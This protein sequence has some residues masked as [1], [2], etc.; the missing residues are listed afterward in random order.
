MCRKCADPQLFFV[1]VADSKVLFTHVCCLLRDFWGLA[2]KANRSAVYR[3]T[4]SAVDL[5]NDILMYLNDVFLC[6]VMQVSAV[7]QERLLRFAVLPVLLGSALQV[8]PKP[9]LTQET[10]WYLLNDLMATLRSHHV[11]T[12]LATS[13]LRPF[14][15][16][17]V[18]Q[19][20]TMSPP[21]TPMGY[22]VMQKS[23]GGT[24]QSSLFEV[25]T[26]EALYES[27]PIPFIT[28]LDARVK[29]LLRN[30]LLEAL[31]ERLR[32]LCLSGHVQVA[33]YALKAVE[34]LM[35]AL[36][37]AGESLDGSV[38]E[39]LGSCLCSCLA[40]HGSLSWSLCLAVLHTLKELLDTAGSKAKAMPAVRERLLAPLAEELLHEAA[41]QSQQGLAAQEAW[42]QAGSGKEGLAGMRTDLEGASK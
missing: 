18:F 15:P 31:E 3:D 23:W 14:L 25:D 34:R 22:Y 20:V 10:A 24:G 40:R 37:S 35:Q 6:E 16:E 13:L 30:Q 39:R 32:E 41:L 1:V 4:K 29:P 42:L 7:L 27:V 28:N 9:L 8:Q 26:S 21:R 12:V 5:Q 19:L 11:L 33:I 17:E 38:A 36:R 2:D